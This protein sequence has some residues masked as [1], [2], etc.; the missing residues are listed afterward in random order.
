MKLA[1]SIDESSSI[2]K[3]IQIVKAIKSEISLGNLKI[4][5]KI[6]SINNLSAEYYLSRDTVEKAYQILK[7]QG[8]IE[9]VKGK[10]YYISHD[11]E[12]SKFKILLLFNKLSAYK[13]EI[14]NSFVTTLEDRGEISFHVYHCEYSLLKKILEQQKELFDF[15]VVM[16]HFKKEVEEKGIE[17]LRSIPSSKLILID[18]N[19]EDF[20]SPFGNIYQDFKYDIYEAM[21]LMESKLRKYKKLILVFPSSANYPYPENIVHGFKKYAVEKDFPFEIIGEINAEHKAEEGNAYVV[22]EEGDLVNLIK[23]ARKSKGIKVGKNLGIISYNETPLKEV[24]QKGITVM[25]T[26]FKAMGKLAAEMILNKEGREIK[27]EFQVIVR[28]SL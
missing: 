7:K 19:L 21:R 12:L 26:D 27:N 13:K 2:P 20:D 23:L 25:S 28:E 18:R 6:P 22:I 15:Y 5:D 24:L 1:L 17:L 16:P 3:Y 14:F 10:G 9:S 4:G 8:I 11:S